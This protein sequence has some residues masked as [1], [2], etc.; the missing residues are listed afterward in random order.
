L[1]IQTNEEY[2]ILKIIKDANAPLGSGIISEKISNMNIEVSEATIGRYL[3]AFDS[4]G[5]T[6]K[7]GF[8]GRLITNEGLEALNRY[9]YEKQ[10]LVK[11][12]YIMNLAKAE[13]KDELINILTARKAIEKE[14]CRL[15]A[16]KVTDEDLVIIAETV[17]KH[18]NQV[19]RG[20]SGAEED[21]DFH[22]TIARAGGNKFLAAALDLIRQDGQLS[23]IFEYIRNTVGS[24]IASD[25]DNILKALENR[26]P[27]EAEKA[28]ARHMDNVIYDV[29]RYWDAVNNNLET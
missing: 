17:E 21:S 27:G 9:E 29:K 22:S 4:K 15:A 24:R 1:P 14:T 2:H 13:A 5:L 25:H 19:Q 20:V 26:D 12:H 18:K 3:R 28:M 8:Q 11:T 6:R 10:L 23:P 16:E 7:I